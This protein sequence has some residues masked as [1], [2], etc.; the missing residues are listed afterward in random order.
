MVPGIL[1]GAFAGSYVT[2][3][4]PAAPLATGFGFFLIYASLS[5]FVEIR[6]KASR[7]LPGPLGMTLMGLV[8]GS[9]SGL[10]GIGGAVI[11]MPM[12]LICNVPL[13]SVIAVAGAFG[14]P[15]A[16][17]GGAGYILAGWGHEGLPPYSLGFVYL[18][19]LLGL[20]PVS[21]LVAPVA[22]RFAHTLPQKVLRRCLG[23][24]IA[25]VACK[26]IAANM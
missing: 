24:F 8:M 7:R 3:F 17:A 10:L 22:V 16:L 23:V 4:I 21:M 26:M 2:K 19:A 1:A 13:L 5:M 11:T 18:P 25:L 15:V 20:I 9:L 6:P 12:L 14:F